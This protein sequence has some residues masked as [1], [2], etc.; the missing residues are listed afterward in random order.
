MNRDLWERLMSA[1]RV[2]KVDWRLLKGHSGI[3]ANERCDVIATSYADKK[4]I[5]LY[6]GSRE[7]YGV[8][9]ALP[10]KMPAKKPSRVYAHSYISLVGGMVTIHKTW[11]DCKEHVDGVSGARFKKAASPEEEAKIAE[12]FK[13]NIL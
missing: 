2:R 9:L 12:E 3:V 11:E 4:P 13:N 5:V 8:S 7:R 6:V 10:E 1:T